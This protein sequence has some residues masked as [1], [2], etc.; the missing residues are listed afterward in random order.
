MHALERSGWFLATR[1][2]DWLTYASMLSMRND[3]LW[4][5]RSSFTEGEIRKATST[6]NPRSFFDAFSHGGSDGPVT[7]R[8]EVLHGG[9]RCNRLWFPSPFVSNVGANNTVRAALYRHDVRSPLALI[10]IGTFGQ[11]FESRSQGMARTIAEQGIDCCHM[12]LPFGQNR[13][14]A[15]AASSFLTTD[16]VA[17]AESFIQA[18]MD[19]GRLA[20][21]LKARYGY[22]RLGLIGICVGGNICHAATFL[23]PYEGAV[24]IMAGVSP[25]DIVWQAGGAYWRR[26]RQGMRRTHTFAEVESLWTMSDTTRYRAPNL[27][28]RF[29]MMNGLYDNVVTPAHARRLNAVIPDCPVVWYPGSHYSSP[30]F[31]GPAVENTVRFFNDKPLKDTGLRPKALTAP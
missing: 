24:F 14:P 23:W 1:F 6:A 26:L 18:V 10:L 8:S 5:R 27:C 7:E 28:P 19:V 25:A 4:A 29:L 21:V 9:I 20:R 17:T 15:H 31:T 16:P 13:T 22:D 11:Q 3:G 12:E 2:F 30:L